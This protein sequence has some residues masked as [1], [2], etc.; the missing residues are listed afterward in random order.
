MWFW[1]M[2][3]SYSNFVIRY[4][5]VIWVTEW[6]TVPVSTLRYVSVAVYCHRYQFHNVLREICSKALTKSPVTLFFVLKQLLLLNPIYKPLGFEYTRFIFHPNLFIYQ[7]NSFLS[8]I[9]FMFF[10]CYMSLYTLLTTMFDNNWQS[11]DEI[12]FTPVINH[13]KSTCYVMHQQF[14][15]QQLYVLPTLYLCVLYLSENKQRLVPLTA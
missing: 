11:Y 14:N 15:I 13:L 9:W 3:N 8:R 4:E 2:I 10:Q 5:S 1:E 12:K 6:V 7:K